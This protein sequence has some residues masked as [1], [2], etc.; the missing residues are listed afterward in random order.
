MLLVLLLTSFVF[1]H[2]RLVLDP[3]DF[4]KYAHYDPSRNYTRNLVATDGLSYTLLFLCWN[5][6]RESPIHDHPC[7]G[8]WMRV[9]EGTIEECRF[10]K[11]PVT[12][13]LDCISHEIYQGK[14]VHILFQYDVIPFVYLLTLAIP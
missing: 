5:P 4:E 8:C 11:N 3:E 14:Y 12:G 10:V 7:D 2:R 13:N 1:H 6:G 9:C